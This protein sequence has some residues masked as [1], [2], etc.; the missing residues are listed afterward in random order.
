MLFKI[1]ILVAF[2]AVQNR[3][4]VHHKSQTHKI[5]E[6]ENAIYFDKTQ[7][8]N[9]RCKPPFQAK[10]KQNKKNLDNSQTVKNEM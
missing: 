3:D 4:T 6:T 1:E 10:T 7:H 8:A 2:Y 9:F 5:L